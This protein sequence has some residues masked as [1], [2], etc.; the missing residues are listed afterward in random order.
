MIVILMGVTGTGKTTVAKALA[1]RTG[2]PFA[3]GDDYHSE[4]NVVKMKAGIPLTDTDRE[5]W[6]EALHGVIAGWVKADSNGVMTCSALKESYRQ[7]LVAGFPED[8]V[9]FVLLEGSKTVLER[10]LER[11]KGH[12]MNPALLNSQLATLEKPKDALRVE[13]TNSPDGEVDTILAGLG[14]T[15]KR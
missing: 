15:A 11:R 14:V 10:R 9:H 5:P 13:V 8:A 4:A 2:W 12:F 3:E 1:L 6:L 7:T